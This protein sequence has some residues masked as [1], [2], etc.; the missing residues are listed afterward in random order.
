MWCGKNS[1]CI[2]NT[3]LPNAQNLFATDEQA[4]CPGEVEF[5]RQPGDVCTSFST[6]P[7][8]G[9]TLLTVPFN[10]DSHLSKFVQMWVRNRR[11]SY[12]FSFKCVFTRSDNNCAEPLLASGLIWDT[13]ASLSDGH[14]KQS[15]FDCVLSP[16]LMRDIDASLPVQTVFMSV[17]WSSEIDERERGER[18]QEMTGLDGWHQIELESSAKDT[19][20]VSVRQ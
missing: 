10:D 20:I 16:Y 13:K 11:L 17:W 15:P 12:Q 3:K 8:T 18:W 9:A 14:S 2:F 5:Y 4:Q 7:S 6:Q 1:K 19:L